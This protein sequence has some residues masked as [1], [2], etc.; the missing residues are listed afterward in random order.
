MQGPV[1]AL[2]PEPVGPPSAVAL[3][4][5]HS[6]SRSRARSRR[7]CRRSIRRPAEAAF[8]IWLAMAPDTET[9]TEDARTR[10]RSGAGPRW[11]RPV[12]VL[13]G[14]LL[15][16]ALVVVLLIVFA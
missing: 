16:V 13:A 5:A 11:V 9:A 12:E 6:A 4:E 1:E 2:V 10:E 3:E 8:D 7:R 15:V 14:L